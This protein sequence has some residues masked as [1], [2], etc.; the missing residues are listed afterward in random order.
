M[1]WFIKKEILMELRYK[2]MTLNL[3]LNPFFMIAP[4]IILAENYGIA[5]HILETMLLWSWMVQFMFGISDS[6]SA[7]KMEGTFVNVLMAPCSFLKY[8]FMEFLFLV[9]DNT[10][11]TAVTLFLTKLILNV[12]VRNLGMFMLEVYVTAFSLFCFS[13]GYTALVLRYKRISGINSFL[14]QVFGFLSGYT[15][16]IKKYPFYLRFVSYCLPL[17]YGIL[18]SEQEYTL[19]L[20]QEIGWI[21][22]SLVFLVVGS[23]LLEKGINDMRIRGDEEEW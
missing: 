19:T 6:I 10:C 5:S 23:F 7:L 2:M 16:S 9:L 1:Y 15:Y 14:Q 22:V 3:W 4:Y 13:I 17:T 21:V 8:Q 20:N 18:F 11:M 12:S